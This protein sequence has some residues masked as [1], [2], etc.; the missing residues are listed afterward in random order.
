MPQESHRQSQKTGHATR[1]STHAPRL[2]TCQL[3]TLIDDHSRVA[4]VEAHTK[5]KKETAA[6]V[7]RNAVAWFADRGV[8]IQR[9]LS[10]NGSA[11]KSH[12]WRE[13]CAELGIVHKRIRPYRPQTNGTIERFHRTL[14]QRWA[15]ARFHDSETSGWQP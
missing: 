8:T 15:I 13:S 3:Q 11:Y 9:V 5:E 12:L 10:H 14:A 2:G 1:N 6:L 7:L 4:Y